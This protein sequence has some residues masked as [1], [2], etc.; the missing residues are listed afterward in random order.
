MLGH[1]C[2]Y[3]LADKA[4]DLRIMQDYLGHRDPRLT[5]IY[6]RVA[7]SRFEGLWK[8]VA[9]SST[10]LE[11]HPGHADE[12]DVHLR[13]PEGLR[14]GPDARNRLCDQRGPVRNLRDRCNGGDRRLQQ[15]GRYLGPP[16]PD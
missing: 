9:S 15:A 3:Y 10:R 11:E 4:T 1:S 14:G 12:I 16:L 7:G 13:R 5:V 8:R 6:T 2:G